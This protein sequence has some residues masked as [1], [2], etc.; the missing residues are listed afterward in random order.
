MKTK[1]EIIAEYE[2]LNR[3]ADSLKSIPDE[4][5][6]LPTAPGKW[7]VAENLAHLMFWNRFILEERLPHIAPDAELV[8]KVDGELKNRQASQYA[9]SGI[10][11]EK[12]VDEWLFVGRQLVDALHNIPEELFHCHYQINGKSMN[13]ISYLQSMLQHDKHHQEQ[14]DLF[15]SGE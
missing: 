3:W 8:S 2:V 11:K 4:L 13:L 1:Q 9:R 5:W 7:S 10:S 15:V 14:I 6:L 12:L